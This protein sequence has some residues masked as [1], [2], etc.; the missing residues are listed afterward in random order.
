MAY[1]NTQSD[2]IVNTIRIANTPPTARELLRHLG[3]A[4]SEKKVVNKILYDFQKSGILESDGGTP[5]RWRLVPERNAH[6][7]M[8][9][10]H[11]QND[12]LEGRPIFTDQMSQISRRPLFSHVEHTVNQGYPGNHF[13]PIF[14]ANHDPFH[15]PYFGSNDLQSQNNNCSTLSSEQQE[16][17]HNVIHSQE[18]IQRDSS[19][20]TE[21][22][23]SQS[24]EEIIRNRIIDRMQN[25]TIEQ[26]KLIETYISS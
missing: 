12:S 15:R 4:T 14:L 11:S 17:T 19:S 24:L 5:P 22:P 26:L 2:L 9:I 8:P 25:M 1:S 23:L 16:H 7:V 13:S 6:V 20:F 21:Q 10:P 3:I 18:G